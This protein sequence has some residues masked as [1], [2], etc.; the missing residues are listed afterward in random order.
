MGTGDDDVEEA[1][2]AVG[3]GTCAVDL[4]RWHEGS[5]LRMREDCRAAEVVVE[6]M[7]I[8]VAVYCVLCIVY[9]VLVV[10]DDSFVLI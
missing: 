6:R 5:L 8:M 1:L 10:T 9:C 7:A 4:N 3:G 2:A